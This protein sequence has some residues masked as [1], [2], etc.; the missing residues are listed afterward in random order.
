MVP[1]ASATSVGHIL[2]SAGALSVGVPREA[3]SR[4]CVVWG[5]S[6]G[7]EPSGSMFELCK[8]HVL[9]NLRIM[10]PDYTQ[11]VGVLAYS[12]FR[13]VL[14]QRVHNPT[15]PQ[16]DE[17][18]CPALL[19]VPCTSIKAPLS[20][21]QLGL[22]CRGGVRQFCD[23]KRWVRAGSC[24]CTALWS[25]VVGGTGSLTLYEHLTLHGQCYW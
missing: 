1:V 15:V 17:C 16:S 19:L 14:R 11:I 7:L 5:V 20:G 21:T 12:T 3:N 2:P 4:P 18:G 9:I 24:C 6:G 8:P 13:F 25:S 10:L 22:H 23:P